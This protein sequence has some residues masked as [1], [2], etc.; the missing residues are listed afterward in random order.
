VEDSRVSLNERF[1][2]LG[3]V[4]EWGDDNVFELGEVRGDEL[5]VIG[6]L[7]FAVDQPHPTHTEVGLAYISASIQASNTSIKLDHTGD[8]SS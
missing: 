3:T 4:D 7:G 5:L 6:T 8:A 1:G 2:D